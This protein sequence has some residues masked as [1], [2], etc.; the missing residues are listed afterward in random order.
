MLAAI[1]SV[2][3]DYD[4]MLD[5]ADDEDAELA[6]NEPCPRSEQVRG[7]VARNWNDGC[8]SCR[9]LLTSIAFDPATGRA[10]DVY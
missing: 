8:R 6:I 7:R 10:D 4:L 5:P 1:A 3:P 9:T 2:L